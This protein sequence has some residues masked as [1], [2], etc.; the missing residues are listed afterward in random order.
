MDPKTWRYMLP[1]WIVA[2]ILLICSISTLVIVLNCCCRPTTP[3]P[4]PVQPPVPMSRMKLSE[5]GQDFPDPRPIKKAEYDRASGPQGTGTVT[6]ATPLAPTPIPA[7]SN[8]SAQHEPPTTDPATRSVRLTMALDGDT[9]RVSSWLHGVVG[10]EFRMIKFATAVFTGKD[11]V[12]YYVQLTLRV[13]NSTGTQLDPTPI[14]LNNVPL[15][16]PGP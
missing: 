1:P 6:P 7:T 10:D 13:Y 16:P 4:D 8:A 9:D 14:V 15:T 11:A 12:N 3:T 5:P 2:W